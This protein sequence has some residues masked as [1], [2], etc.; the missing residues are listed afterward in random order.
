MLTLLSALSAS[1]TIQRPQFLS[2]SAVPLWLH[3]WGSSGY[4]TG[5]LEQ[6]PRRAAQSHNHGISARTLVADHNVRSK[7]AI[8]CDT[9]ATDRASAEK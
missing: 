2:A 9:A 8:R 6:D 5:T 7:S 1:I 4:N 3:G